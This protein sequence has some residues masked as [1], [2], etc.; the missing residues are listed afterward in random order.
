M[1]TV[2]LAAVITVAV[3][4][5][6]WWWSEWRI[7][8]QRRFFRVFGLIDGRHLGLDLASDGVFLFW[9]N[10]LVSMKD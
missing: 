8:G 4:V 5:G 7:G 6:F 2:G 1:A 9:R 3:L 10:T